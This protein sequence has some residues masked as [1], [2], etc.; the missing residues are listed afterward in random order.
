MGL[1][2][3][4]Q[5]RIGPAIGA[6]QE[7]VETLRANGDRSSNMAEALN[8]LADALAMG[9]MGSQSAPL[10]LEAQELARGLKN[11]SL[12]ASILNSQ[13]DAYFYQGD[14][15][16]AKGSYDQAVRMAARTSDKDLAL[17]S[18]LNAN[19]LAIN[20]GRS[21]AAAADLQK[22]MQQADSQGRKYISVLASTL[23]AE[24]MIAGGGQVPARQELQR[25]LGKSERLGTRL[26]T[27]RIHFLLGKTLRLTG[28]TS[29]ARSQYLQAKSLLD[30]I[31]KE[32]G[33]EH[34]LE[35]YDLKPIY[36]EIKQFTN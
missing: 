12:L 21:R 31:A 8:D 35:R 19:R 34:L 24:A 15:R 16:S 2:F 23:F 14:L 6:L 11:E 17:I 28:S 10:I 20:D 36:D 9:G 3:E 26:E 13:G 7:A 30:E 4:T 32:Q 5:G 22:L 1:I 18:R 29:D 33:A 27:A 25:N